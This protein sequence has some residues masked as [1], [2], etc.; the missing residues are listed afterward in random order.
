MTVSWEVVR[1]ETS[2]RLSSLQAS[3]SR[4]QAALNLIHRYRDQG[5]SLK[6]VLNAILSLLEAGQSVHQ[7]DGLALDVLVALDHWVTALELWPRWETLLRHYVD[8]AR[9]QQRYEAEIVLLNDLAVIVQQMGRAAEARDI[10]MQGLAASN[11]TIPPQIIG[12]ILVQGVWMA[13]SLNDLVQAWQ[14]L[15]S[16]RAIYDQLSPDDQSVLL[17]YILFAGADYARR[18]GNLPEAVR[19]ARESISVFEQDPHPHLATQAT[20]YR[21]VGVY[22]W[23]YGNHHSALR[24]LKKAARLYHSLGDQFGVAWAYGNQG[25]AYRSL[26]QL[27]KSER[28][29]KRGIAISKQYGAY[30]QITFEIGNFPDIYLTAGQIERARLYAIRHW[31]MSRKFNIRTEAV[32]AIGNMGL[33]NI[34]RGRYKA[35]LRLLRVDY[36]Y[37]KANDRLETLSFVSGRLAEC[38]LRLNRLWRAR[39]FAYAALNLSR[40]IRSRRVQVMALRILAECV[41]DDQAY[42]YLNQA[43]TLTDI[44][45]YERAACE[46]SLLRFVD[47]EAERTRRW[48]ILHDQLVEMGCGAYLFDCDANHPPR[49]LVCI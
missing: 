8:V 14:A 40:R 7:A 21:M 27:Q 29:T 26:G 9:Q 30:W 5:K 17:G 11:P 44:E 12:Q 18:S 46:V 3:P 13:L 28:A 24:S 48:N 22:E 43:L 34:Q 4:L 41:P 32:R 19:L 38:Y 23:A 31:A 49:W 1:E 16:T 36:K 10:A 33:I 39:I 15:E 47:D 37:C 6:P 35:A 20:V 42:E 25:L 2:R 45:S